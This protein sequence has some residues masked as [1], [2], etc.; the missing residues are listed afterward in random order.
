MA[1]CKVKNKVTKRHEIVRK[2]LKT[3]ETGLR[4]GGYWRDMFDKNMTFR[5]IPPLKVLKISLPGER[6]R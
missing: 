4:N 5:H 3:I 6:Q 1:S 2:L